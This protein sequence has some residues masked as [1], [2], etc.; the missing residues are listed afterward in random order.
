[1]FDTL[2]EALDIWQKLLD[3]VY[4]HHTLNSFTSNAPKNIRVYVLEEA[5]E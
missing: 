2:Q 3:Q 4:G 1:V 5:P